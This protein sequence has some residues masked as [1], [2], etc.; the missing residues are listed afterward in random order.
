MTGKNSKSY[1]ENSNELI[2]EYNNSYHHSIG[3]KILMLI[4]LICLEKL[5]QILSYLSLKLVLE[6]ELLIT[7]IF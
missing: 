7:K 1:H 4:I 2:H 6:S 3:K 5:T